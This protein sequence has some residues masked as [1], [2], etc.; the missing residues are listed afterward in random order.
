LRALL[1]A[2]LAR[3]L[4]PDDGNLLSLSGGVDSTALGA[5]AAGIVGRK[6]WTFSLLPS[7]EDKTS[8]EHELSFIEPLAQ[9]YGFAR[10]WEIHHHPRLLLDLYRSSH[11][12]SPIVFHV[13]HPTLCSLPRIIGEAPVRVLFGG[14]FADEMCGSVFTIPDWLRHT[15]F[16]RLML[17]AQTWIKQPRSIARWAKHRW[18]ALQGESWLVF[19]RNLLEIDRS[20]NKPRELFNTAVRQEYLDWWDGKKKQVL[21]D[22]DPWRHLSMESATMDS[23]VPMNWEACSAL[24]VRRS[25]PFFNREIFELVYECHPTELFGPGTKKLLRAALHDDV[26]SRNLYRQDKGSWGIHERKIRQ[27]LQESVTEN[28]PLELAQVLSPEWFSTLPTKIA[29]SQFNSMTRLSI[30]VDSLR[31]RQADREFKNRRA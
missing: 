11:S 23:F 29:Y 27:S 20:T 7:Q 17:D 21:Q 26:P 31:R 28:L 8:L 25:F 1:I 15:S 4:D 30:F 3:D 9:E 13:L 16:L 12:A 5:L 14:E 24:G 10:R 18:A 19:P 6:V 2:K 22:Q